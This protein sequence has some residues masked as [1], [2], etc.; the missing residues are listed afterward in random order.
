MGQNWNV[1]STPASQYTT[2]L[3]LG[4]AEKEDFPGFAGDGKGC[5]KHVAVRSLQQL[6]WGIEILDTSDNILASVE[7]EEED[8]RIAVV[9]EVTYYF[10]NREVDIPIPMLRSVA[11]PVNVR[12]NS[13]TAKNAGATG[14]IT[15]YFVLDK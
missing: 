3:D 7:F 14:Y 1:Q 13:S 6:A 9:D 5:I 15:V 8:A 12:N 4:E 10:Y 2:A 11:V